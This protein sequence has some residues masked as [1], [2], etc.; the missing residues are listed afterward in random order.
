MQ[1]EQQA[2]VLRWVTKST[3]NGPYTQ[4]YS[5][6]HHLNVTRVPYISCVQLSILDFRCHA[7]LSSRATET[8]KRYFIS[9]GIRHFEE[10]FDR[11][12]IQR[13]A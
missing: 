6:T 11:I 5:T 10:S 2:A 9:N 4:G 12:Y 13:V 7:R 3:F 8:E 1:D